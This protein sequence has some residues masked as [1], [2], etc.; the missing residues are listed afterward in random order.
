[1]AS[2]N[3]H[4]RVKLCWILSVEET[5]IC[6]KTML[7]IKNRFSPFRFCLGYFALH[8]M[9]ISFIAEQ[10]LSPYQKEKGSCVSGCE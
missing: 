7:L 9:H 10:N 4:N 3:W 5:K 6:A 1:M 2:Q 8:N